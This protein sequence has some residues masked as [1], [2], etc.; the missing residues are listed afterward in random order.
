MPLVTLNSLEVISIAVF[1]L[2]GT[3]ANAT[4]EM[5]TY[6][7]TPMPFR[8]CLCRPSG[9]GP[10]PL[11]VFNH[12]GLGNIIRGAPREFC[13]ALEKAGFVGLAPIRRQTRSIRGHIDDVFA[14]MRYGLNLPCG[15]AAGRNVRLIEYPP[16]G[17]D[18][19][20]M[21]FGVGNY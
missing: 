6:T 14:G 4:A 12:G 5:V 7:S 2:S 18:G 21:F 13:A 9:R 17:A 3:V 15:S 20:T 16:Y 11:V 19:H 10:F 8:G 1:V